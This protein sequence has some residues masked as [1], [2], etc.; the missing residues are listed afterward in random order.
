MHLFQLVQLLHVDQFCLST[1]EF[2]LLI[3]QVEQLNNQVLGLWTI[4]VFF[5][6]YISLT[7]C[8]SLSDSFLQLD[9]LSL[10]DIKQFLIDHLPGKLF[11]S[12][13]PCWSWRCRAF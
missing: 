4:R 8:R 2:I 5:I 6:P 11:H 12:W 3:D 1:E 10:L 7:C 9:S 13:G